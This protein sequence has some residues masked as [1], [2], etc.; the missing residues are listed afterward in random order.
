[1]ELC[2]GS[3]K[4]Y[5]DKQYEGPD[6]NIGIPEMLKQAVSGLKFLHQRNIVHRDIRPQKILISQS[7]EGAPIQIKLSGFA[8]SKIAKDGKSDYS[9]SGPAPKS[10]GWKACEL[11]IGDQMERHT[12]SVDIFAMGCVIYYA[13]TNGEHPFGYRDENVSERRHNLPEELPN[14]KYAIELIESMINDNPEKRPSAEEVLAQPFFI[15][16]LW[17]AKETLDFIRGLSESLSSSITCR[18]SSKQQLVIDELE[19]SKQHIFPGNWKEQFSPEMQRHIDSYRPYSGNTVF[20][21]LKAIRNKVG[22]T[23]TFFILCLALFLFYSVKI[24]CKVVFFNI[25]IHVFF[26]LSMFIMKA[27]RKKKKV[28][29]ARFLTLIGTTGPLDFQI[30]SIMHGQQESF[31]MN[32]ISP[33]T[34]YCFKA[35]CVT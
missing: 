28:N 21:L 1:M 33:K 31:F 30:S 16:G 20:S 2:L 24:A 3:L 17:S 35:T 34:I 15:L 9:M 14:Y 13:L 26:R 32:K 12:N 11:L 27:A 19:K 5:I 18:R 6:I 8:I 10:Q 22:H 4:Q 23:K 29:M 25:V 7:S